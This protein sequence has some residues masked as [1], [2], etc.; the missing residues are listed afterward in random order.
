MEEQILVRLPNWSIFLGQV[1]GLA[2][3]HLVSVYAVSLMCVFEAYDVWSALIKGSA[4][5]L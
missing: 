1:C 3:M 4:R 5:A 2:K